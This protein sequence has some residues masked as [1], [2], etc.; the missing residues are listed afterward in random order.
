MVHI[1]PAGSMGSIPGQGTKNSHAAWHSQKKTRSTALLK[2]TSLWSWASPFPFWTPF[3]LM[4]RKEQSL[5]PWPT[6]VAAVRIKSCHVC[7]MLIHHYWLLWL[8]YYCAYYYYYYLIIIILLLWLIIIVLPPC[9]LVHSHAP[10]EALL[11][12][13]LLCDVPGMGVGDK[14]LNQTQWLESRLGSTRR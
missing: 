4:G 3:P 6:P 10:E 8:I 1:S 12:H 9:Q 11:L 7:F 14:C 2:G 13:Q 5:T